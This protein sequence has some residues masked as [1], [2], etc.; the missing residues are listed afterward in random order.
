MILKPRRALILPRHKCDLTMQALMVGASAAP[1]ATNL[2]LGLHFEDADGSLLFEEATGKVASISRSARIYNPVNDYRLV[3]DFPFDNATQ[4]TDQTGRHTLGTFNGNNPSSGQDYIHFVSASTQYGEF[5]INDTYQGDLDANENYKITF[6]LSVR[7]GTSSFAVIITTGN[8]YALT[9][10]CVVLGVNINMTTKK[11]K[12]TLSNGGS[13]SNGTVDH[14]CELAASPTYTTFYPVTLTISGNTATA[15]TN[16]DSVSASIPTNTWRHYITNKGTTLATRVSTSS[17]GVPTYAWF[18]SMAVKNYKHYLRDRYPASIPS[19]GSFGKWALFTGG[20]LLKFDGHADF[21][22]NSS[23]N[24][25]ICGR[26]MLLSGPNDSLATV[27]PIY[28]GDIT[29]TTLG[30]RAYIKISPSASGVTVN[31][32]GT[33]VSG[34]SGGFLSTAPRDTWHTFMIARDG[35]ANQ[36]RVYL[37]GTQVGATA[38][39]H[40]ALTTPPVYLGG[41]RD[42][43]GTLVDYKGWFF[44]DDF[45]IRKTC[46]QTGSSYSVPTTPFP[47]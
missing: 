41:G 17:G 32:F 26:F 34:G 5:S 11:W 21:T 23:S 6:D 2:A 22:F 30:T 47:L 12:L 25:T 9:T 29:S 4:L 45:Y 35:T 1:P 33:N 27:I 43:A 18:A 40:I 46:E 31:F 8:N 42:T 14:D 24:W 3:A 37:D 28:I 38:S 36:T 7:V 20:D 15:S 19:N 13:A 10:F 44:L 39:N 16:L